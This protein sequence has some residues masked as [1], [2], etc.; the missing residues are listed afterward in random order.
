MILCHRTVKQTLVKCLQA[1]YNTLARSYFSLSP[2]TPIYPPEAKLSSLEKRIE[3]D[4]ARPCREEIILSMRSFYMLKTL[5]IED[6]REKS[7]IKVRNS[8][9]AYSEK[10]PRLGENKDVCL[11]R[12]NWIALIQQMSQEMPNLRRFL[13]LVFGC[14]NRMTII[15]ILLLSFHLL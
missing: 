10:Y 9:R 8:M 2:G 13:A 7:Q 1:R 6:L 5:K 15:F 4:I 11:L 14:D 3:N 12:I